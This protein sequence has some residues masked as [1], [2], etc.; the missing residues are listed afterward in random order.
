VDE[1]PEYTAHPQA[2]DRSKR[3]WT[4]TVRRKWYILPIIILV[5]IVAIIGG[6]IGNNHHQKQ[7]AD[8]SKDPPAPLI[9]ALT[10]TECVAGTFVF[11]QVNTGEI[12]LHGHLWGGYWNQTSSQEIPSIN[13]HLSE[14][15][16]RPY[17]G[18]NLTAVCYTSVNETA[19]EDIIVSIP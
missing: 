15:N 4:E 8:A 12:Y 19:D 17:Y 3:G 9:T 11:Y 6:V 2:P 5:I 16:L 14:T 18:S 1:L 7:Q 10:A 13:L